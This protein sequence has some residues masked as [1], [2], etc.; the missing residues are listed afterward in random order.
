MRNSHVKS[1]KSKKAIS[2]LFDTKSK[3]LFSKLFKISYIR[4][5]TDRLNF[6]IAVN[7]KKFRTSPLRNKVKR[8]IRS[9]VYETNLKGY[10]IAIF[11][12]T[13]VNDTKYEL[14]KADFNNLL[15]KIA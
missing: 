6:L 7:K 1:L 3:S 10:D 15:S 8:W 13:T 2:A 12:N 14:I 9:I 4:N 5:N 11:A